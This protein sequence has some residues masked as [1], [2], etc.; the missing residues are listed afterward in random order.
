MRPLAVRE[1]QRVVL[2]AHM[3]TPSMRER[4][5]RVRV[6]KGHPFSLRRSGLYAGPYV[7]LVEAEPMRIELLPKIATDPD[8]E[9][10]QQRD[11]NIL[12]DLLRRTRRIPPGGVPASLASRQADILEIVARSAADTLVQELACGAPRRYARVSEWSSSIRGRIDFARLARRLPGKAAPG[13]E[14]SHDRREG[15][16]A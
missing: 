8:P 16:P 5:L 10:R 2:P 13:K 9:A 6:G 3:D 12:H 14:V 4:L 11:R 1:H 7:G 15:G